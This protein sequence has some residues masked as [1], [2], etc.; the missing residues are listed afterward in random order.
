L[1]FKKKW[2]NFLNKC[3]KTVNF[4]LIYIKDLKIEG[5]AITGVIIL[6]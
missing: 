6:A 4:S 3:N 1:S 5:D 2:T